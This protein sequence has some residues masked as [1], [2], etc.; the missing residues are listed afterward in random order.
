MLYFI[1]DL[2]HQF[3]ILLNIF[4]WLVVILSD[5]FHYISCHQSYLSDPF[6]QIL[7]QS[8]PCHLYNSI[9]QH[10]KFSI[11]SVNLS[12]RFSLLF[13]SIMLC[14]IFINC[15][16]ISFVFFLILSSLLRFIFLR[17]QIILFFIFFFIHIFTYIMV[18]L[19][20]IL[21]QHWVLFIFITFFLVLS[22]ITVGGGLKNDPV[23][24]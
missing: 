20:F 3:P 24:P 2:F 10:F 13:L 8:Y 7:C 18:R 21:I 1:S 22:S 23:N 9:F 19:L 11:P 12:S 5:I 15:C 16:I 14:Y 4:H 6:R 17:C